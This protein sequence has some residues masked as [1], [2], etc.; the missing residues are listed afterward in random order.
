MRSLAVCLIVGVVVVVWGEGGRRDVC[1]D[2]RYRP[3]VSTP[4]YMYIFLYTTTK[5]KPRTVDLLEHVE[6]GLEVVVVQVPDQGVFQV[7]LERDCRAMIVIEV[8]LYV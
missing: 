4:Q 6:H 2:G 5:G 7:L 1:I 8:C 3:Y